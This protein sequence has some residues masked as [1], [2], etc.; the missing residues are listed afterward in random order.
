MGIQA[1]KWWAAFW[2]LCNF[3]FRAASLHCL[4]AAG[5]LF[6]GIGIAVFIAGYFRV[7]PV[8]RIMFLFG[9]TLPLYGFQPYT[10]HSQLF[11][12]WLVILAGIFLHRSFTE[13]REERG[14]GIGM[15]LLGGYVL[16]A[17][18]SLLV[19]PLTEIR[20]LAGLWGWADLFRLAQTSL[21]ENP[22]FSILSV[23]RLVL[24]FLLILFISHS[25]NA[26][27][28]YRALFSGCGTGALLACALGLL[29][30]SG[31]FDLSLYRPDFPDASGVQR[32]HSVFG[33]PGWFAEYTVVCFPLLLYFTCRKQGFSIFWFCAGTTLVAAGLFLTGSRTSWLVFPVLVG[34]LAFTVRIY[35]G[36]MKGRKV[37]LRAAAALLVTAI[38]AGGLYRGSSEVAGES[39]GKVSRFRYL[40][41]RLRHIGVSDERGKLWPESIALIRE[42][43]FFG[44]GY[45]TYRWHTKSMDSIDRSRFFRARQTSLSWE[46]P[47]NL[48]LQLLA[49]N[50]VVGLVLWLCIAGYAAFLLGRDLAVR[51]NLLSGVLLG[52]LLGFHLYGMGQ[53]MQYVPSVW[54]L[55]FFLFG[56]AFLLENG[57]SGPAP[58]IRLR[59][60]VYGILLFVTAAATVVYGRNFESRLLAARYNL[61]RYGIAHPAVQYR[62]F[63][64]PENWGRQGIMRWTG[65]RA[66]IVLP[67]PGL[68][69]FLLVNNAPQLEKNAIKVRALVN[70]RLIDSYV[71]SAPGK[72]E[73]VF[74]VPVSATP[75]V[76]RLVV[77]RTWN[78]R[79]EG[80]SRDSR[81]LGVAVGGPVYLHSV[82]AA[83]M[84][85][86]GRGAESWPLS[87]SSTMKKGRPVQ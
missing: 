43:P 84:L 82:P 62:G 27:A 37:L 53:S 17:V 20:H 76:F 45:G 35:F 66:E 56:Y 68:V 55:V 57:G 52:M 5:N 44:L 13:E 9:L 10:V 78:P 61:A 33:N 23:H 63:Y 32:L 49:D 7:V 6:I 48:Y 21:P 38:L 50:G 42:Q 24:F 26:D 39:P 16:L 59:R 77:S 41:E 71:F 12:F 31:L 75:A 46:T 11:E 51:R 29:N 65:R 25:R 3:L 14:P 79:L 60:V 81:N 19:L 74:R 34:Y 72:R 15:A 73:L 86:D 67:R 28:V 30:Q 64:A 36:K 70:T 69:R 47:H 18:L 58:D 2:L 40:G 22:L 54:I 8:R 85:L 4:G 1:L 80:L 87:S 83:L